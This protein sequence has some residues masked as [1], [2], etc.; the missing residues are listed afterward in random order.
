MYRIKVHDTRVVIV[1]KVGRGYDDGVVRGRE[2]LLG[3][4]VGGVIELVWMG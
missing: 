2:W 3:G 4:L 1:V